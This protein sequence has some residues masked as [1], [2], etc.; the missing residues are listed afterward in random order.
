MACSFF[1]C[2]CCGRLCTLCVA[3]DERVKIL[4]LLLVASSKE[5]PYALSALLAQGFEFVEQVFYVR[6]R[7]EHRL[8]VVNLH[9]NINNAVL[10]GVFECLLFLE[11]GVLRIFFPC[12]ERLAAFTRLCFCREALLLQ[13]FLLRRKLERLICERR[14]LQGTARTA[15]SIDVG[16]ERCILRFKIRQLR[17]RLMCLLGS[18]H[19]DDGDPAIFLLRRSS[20]RRLGSKEEDCAAKSRQEQDSESTANFPP[21]LFPKTAALR[22]FLRHL[23][24]LPKSPCI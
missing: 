23:I 6:L 9:L 20:R 10:I 7:K 24:H 12:S 19:I 3:R 15:Q 11:K 2:A 22:L 17:I 13:I 16:G 8:S 21:A 5:R 4:P 14:R 18:R 1:L